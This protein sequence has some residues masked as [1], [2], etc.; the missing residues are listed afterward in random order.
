MRQGK[1]IEIPNAD[2]SKCSIGKI[3]PITPDLGD[4]VITISELGGVSITSRNASEI[5]YTTNGSIPNKLS[6]RY[7]APFVVESDTTIKAISYKGSETSNVSTSVYHDKRVY[8]FNKKVNEGISPSG[9]EHLNRFYLPTP[10]LQNGVEYNI[11]LGF[12]IPIPKY[13]GWGT[14]SSPLAVRLVPDSGVITGT[15][16]YLAPKETCSG[17]ATTF[18]AEEGNPFIYLY[19][20][21]AGVQLHAK[22]DDS[23]AFTLIIREL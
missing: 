11:T 8:I 3:T 12:T 13:A 21:T 1:V 10:D 19:I 4:P 9:L 2:F 23:Y 5:Y 22:P 14:A 20:D 6:N 15:D 7:S 18:V 16:V 17:M